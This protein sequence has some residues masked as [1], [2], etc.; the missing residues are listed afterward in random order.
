MQ[1]EDVGE[2]AARVQWT[3]NDVGPDFASVAYYTVAYGTDT[4]NMQE[5]NVTGKRLVIIAL[6]NLKKKCNY[7]HGNTS[8][9]LC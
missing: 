3:M 7:C 6:M 2:S 9:W 8:I 5:Q 1:F 4:D